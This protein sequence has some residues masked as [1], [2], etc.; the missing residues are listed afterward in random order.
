MDLKGEAE[1]W[2]WGGAACD[3]PIVVVAED[4]LHELL[5]VEHVVEH[6][7]LLLA[8]TYEFSAISNIRKPGA[9]GLQSSEVKVGKEVEDFGVRG[10]DQQVGMRFF[11]PRSQLLASVSEHTTAGK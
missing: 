5:R 1:G 6:D 2:P 4:H 11:H 3:A 10:R 9:S 8:P 7:P